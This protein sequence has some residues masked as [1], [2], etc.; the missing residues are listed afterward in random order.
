M[1][2]SEARE[3]LIELQKVINSDEHNKL[4]PNSRPYF[5]GLTEILLEYLP[6]IFLLLPAEVNQ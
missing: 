5:S 4:G 1:T 2:Y 6:Q 3:A